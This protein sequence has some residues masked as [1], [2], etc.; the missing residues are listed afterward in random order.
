MYHLQEP[1]SYR[2]HL[3]DSQGALLAS[4]AASQGNNELSLAFWPKGIYVLQV[5]DVEHWRQKTFK[6]LRQ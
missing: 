6:L 5:L 2:Y 1:G 4:G 3:Y